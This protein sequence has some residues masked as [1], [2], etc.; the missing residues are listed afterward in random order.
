MKKS[1]KVETLEELNALIQKVKEAQNQFAT[2][3]EEKVSAIF[4][5]AAIAATVFVSKLTL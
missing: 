5:A 2:F 3:S 4:K 1:Q